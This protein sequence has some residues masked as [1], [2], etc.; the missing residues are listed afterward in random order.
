MLIFVLQADGETAVLVAGDPEREHMRKVRQDGGIRYHVNLLQAMVSI[1][2]RLRARKHVA[3]TK[4]EKTCK[5][6]RG[7]ENAFGFAPKLSEN[8]TSCSEWSHHFLSDDSDG[9]TKDTRDQ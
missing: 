1:H 8:T 5:I 9:S 6:W 7:R 3:G 4:R 2:K